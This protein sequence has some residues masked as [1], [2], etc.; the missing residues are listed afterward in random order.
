[1]LRLWFAV[2]GVAGGLCAG[3]PSILASPRSLGQRIL[4]FPIVAV[5]DADPKETAALAAAL[6]EYRDGGNME[7]VAPFERFLTERPGSPW[8]P[9]L[10]SAVGVIDRQNGYLSRALDRFEESWNELKSE[11]APAARTIA[12]VTLGNLAE[13]NAALGRT[14]RLRSLLKEVDGRRLGGYAAE[15]VSSARVG[16]AMMDNDPGG[17]FRCGPLAVEQV[18]RI[19]WPGKGIDPAIL[20]YRSTATGTSL[21]ELSRLAEKA[22]LGLKAVYRESANFVV[23]SVLHWKAGHFAALIAENGGRYRVKD[24]TFGDDRWVSREAL[25]AETSGYMLIPAS[26]AKDGF[27]FVSQSEAAGVRGQGATGNPNP[28]ATTP[29][30]PKRPKGC[31]SGSG[32]GMPVYNFHIAIV[33]LNVTDTPVGYS[34]PRGP[35]M[36]FRI[37]YNSREQQPSALTFS[38]LGPRWLFGWLSY[39]EDDGDSAH[40]GQSV[41]IAELG[42]GSYTFTAASDGSYPINGAGDHEQLSMSS[43]GGAIRFIR[44]Y[45][46]GSAAVYSAS[47]GATTFRKY[48]LTSISDPSGNTATFQYDVSTRLTG[49]ADALG[50]RTTIA[51]GDPGNPYRITG[52]QDPFGRS[53]SFTYNSNGMLSSTTDSIGMTSTFSYGPTTGSPRAPADFMNAMTTPYGTTTF[54][55]DEYQPGGIPGTT[56]WLQATNP[57]GE[58]ERVEFIQDA[59][60][61]T[62]KTT[63]PV[64]LG[65]TNDLLEF[66][67]TFYWDATAMQSYDSSD[68]DRYKK[69]TTV[70]HWLHDNT[71]SNLLAA[72]VPESVQ[73]LGERR[74]W[75]LYPG[76]SSSTYIGSLDQPGTIARVLDSGEEQRYTIEYN[77][78]GKPKSYEDPIGRRYDLYYSGDG[79]DLLDVLDNSA[80]ETLASITYDGHHRP[81]SWTDFA[82]RSTSASYNAFGEVSSVSA[83][84]GTAWSF[85]YDGQ[86]YR[87]KVSQTSSGFSET[88]TYDSVGRVRTWT[89]ADGLA[90]TFDYD[91]LDRLT[92]VTY[93]D[94]SVETTIYDRLDPVEE[95]DRL[96]RISRYEYD[97]DGRNVS[98]TDPSGLTTRYEWCGCGALDGMT[99]PGGR[100]VDWLHDEQGRAIARFSN[101]NLTWDREY[102]S[103]GRLVATTDANGQTKTVT[104]NSDDTASRFDYVNTLHPT[105]SVRWTWDQDRRRVLSMSDGTGTTTYA[106]V[107]AGS[108][109]AGQ[110]AAIM[111]PTP[112][113]TIAFTYDALGRVLQRSIDGTA[114]SASYDALGRAVQMTS[115]LGKATVSYDGS[116]NRAKLFAFD[117]GQQTKIGYG[118]AALGFPVTYVQRALGNGYWAGSSYSFDAAGDQI[119]Q[120]LDETG[121]NMYFEYDPDQRL[122]GWTH[123]TD[124]YQPDHRLTLYGY[125]AAG[126]RTSEAI[127]A[128][129]TTATYDNENRLTVIHRGLNQTAM[130]AIREARRGGR[131]VAPPKRPSGVETGGGR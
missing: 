42:G 119:T 17:S 104:Y 27:R 21:A 28:G 86:G 41:R 74:I 3:H 11:Q 87:T 65:M 4:P 33:S 57:M 47:D 23:P 29:K 91:A 10:R 99:D 83:A 129:I 63:D 66:R 69:A 130:A 55:M 2:L 53:A 125:D 31:G 95:H 32:N 67:N 108:P 85:T 94:G 24:L 35:T 116:S 52:I 80:G 36:D 112:S 19:E 131:R 14:E 122:T 78:L 34:P 123:S 75:F 114:I 115:P 113:H 88:Y 127:D 44:T 54:A 110:L 64:P 58:S 124:Q 128:T 39:V 50:Q 76:Q 5:R 79:V 82:G 49:I 77:P 60:G 107:P 73:N 72:S 90:L 20:D 6:A 25:E 15:Q 126:N 103:A 71:G 45:P 105:P 118:V 98:A 46:D 38:N 56:R 93:P 22:G 51:Y 102:D 40:P 117:N 7:A 30:D 106:Y 13:L 43:S 109:G 70:V 84:D 89:S 18:S 101:G 37:T 68:A 9:A 111:L 59:P 16:L 8:T 120:V 121:T 96:G 12:D 48:F 61:I 100:R 92:A 26:G 81:T 62:P 1:M 97:A